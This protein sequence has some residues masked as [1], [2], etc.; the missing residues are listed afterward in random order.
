MAVGLG[1]IPQSDGRRDGGRSGS[2][3]HLSLTEEGMAVGLG[4]IPQYDGR[5]EMW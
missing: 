1:V 4:A 2:Y 3:I 5:M